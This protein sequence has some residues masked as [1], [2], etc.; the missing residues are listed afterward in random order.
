MEEKP[1]YELTEKELVTELSARG[2]EI[3]PNYY[4]PTFYLRNK[5][6]MICSISPAIKNLSSL[7][8]S[9]TIP[10]SITTTSEL[11]GYLNSR[12]IRIDIAKGA[13][14]HEVDFFFNL[15]EN[16][17]AWRTEP[18]LLEVLGQYSP[19]SLTLQIGRNLLLGNPVSPDQEKLLYNRIVIYHDTRP[20][21]SNPWISLLLNKHHR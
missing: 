6:R 10:E 14:G 19:K 13:L 15:S 17:D 16:I 8:Y 20:S 1:Y 18:L 12:E 2:F 9:K 4:G 21:I 7:G 3:L 5:D 11:T